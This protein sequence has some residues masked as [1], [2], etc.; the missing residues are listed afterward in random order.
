MM[1]K[2][3]SEQLR[4]DIVRALRMVHDKWFDPSVRLGTG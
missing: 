3:E 2:N 1:L 4:K